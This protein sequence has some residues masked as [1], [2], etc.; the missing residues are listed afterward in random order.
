VSLSPAGPIRNLDE[1]RNH[2]QYAIGIELATI[3]AY[4]YALYS[5][6]EGKNTAVA[7]VIQSVALE[8][9]LHMTLAANVL[10]AIGGVPS[11]DPVTGP[12]AGNPILAYPA[13]VP[14]I[15]QIP[16]IHLRR[17]SREAVDTF[18][19][20]E[21]PA[22]PGAPAGPAAD[23]QQYASIGEFYA[24]IEEGLRT[25]GTDEIF[26]EARCSRHGC[27][28]PPRY[29]YGGAG[30]LIEVTDLASA[31][32]ALDEIVRE[33]EG[34]PVETLGQTVAEYA[35]REATR[36]G[37]ARAP[38]VD[39]GDVLPYGWK[40]YS[41]YA[42]FREIRE[43]R[44]YRPAQL[45]A[46]RPAGDVLPVEWAAVLP[47]AADPKARHVEGTAAWAPM[48][49][50]DL[51]YSDLVDTLYRA[52]NGEPQALQSAV[53]VMYDLKYQ[54]VAL[55]RT[56]SPLDP[57]TT[58]GPGFEYLPA[59]ARTDPPAPGRRRQPSFRERPGMTITERS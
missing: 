53:T 55:M 33:G 13:A 18:L 5:I 36:A 37:A 54:A 57:S 8:E 44:R 26:A 21:Q 52:Y 15:D 42:R 47:A 22:E 1:L 48:V 41:H 11:P 27:Q 38:G 34:V 56:P 19:R 49:E 30:R 32:D 28:V 51:T 43:G 50:C 39:D 25:L 20:I 16:P 2:L 40:M 35:E 10:N 45:V 12:E 59:T 6:E 7:E 17:F 58:L 29:Y 31:L 14:F 24:A 23:G 9:M 46:D 3:P 4:L